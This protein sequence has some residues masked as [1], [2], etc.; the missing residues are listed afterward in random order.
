MSARWTDDRQSAPLKV[1]PLSHWQKEGIR[2]DTLL[3]QGTWKAQYLP[4]ILSHLSIIY[5]EERLG[6]RGRVTV[7][8]TYFRWHIRNI[9]PALLA[10]FYLG[11]PSPVSHA[12]MHPSCR[13]P[14][15]LLSSSGWV[16]LGAWL[17]VQPCLV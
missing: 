1:K 2:I 10:T 13:H 11:N 14:V 3:V 16:Q 9:Y 4:L 12:F 6:R 15:C 17:A 8:S 5:F 7:Q